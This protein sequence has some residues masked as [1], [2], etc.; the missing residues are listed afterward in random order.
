MQKMKAAARAI[1]S[2]GAKIAVDG[3]IDQ[4][5]AAKSAAAAVVFSLLANSAGAVCARSEEMTALQASA[6][7][8]ELMVAGLMCHQ[9]RAFNQFITSHQDEYRDLDRVLLG[10]FTRKDGSA[11]DDAYN[12]Y[13][14]RQA[15]DASMRSY[16]DERFCRDA[17]AAFDSALGRNL[18]L[19]DLVL[20]Q[21][22]FIS[23]GY[24]RCIWE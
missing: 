10:F 18:S 8:Q 21:T 11:G 6:L 13:K 7:R 24:D 15:N 22:S 9:A 1:C 17:A 20:E 5:R 3:R 16:T 12:A 19:A 14:T 23:T 2:V 4:R